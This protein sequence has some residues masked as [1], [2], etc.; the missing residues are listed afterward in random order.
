MDRALFW[1]SE[2]EVRT[3]E[4]KKSKETVKKLSAKNLRVFGDTCFLRA[5]IGFIHTAPLN[6]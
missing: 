3:R 6:N 1:N 2:S 4:K 5:S